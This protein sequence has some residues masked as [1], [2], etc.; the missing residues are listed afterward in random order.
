MA[1]IGLAF[2][3]F[4]IDL[5]V[6]GF[7]LS[8]AG[9]VSFV[10]GSLLLFSPFTPK[11]PAMPRLSVSPWLLGGMTALLV[12]FFSLALTAAL[13]AQRR[14]VL[15]SPRIAAGATGIALTALDPQ[16]VVQVQSE[17]WTART[18]GEPVAMGA[19]VEIVKCDGLRLQ[20]RP[21]NQEKESPTD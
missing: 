6:A 3:F 14:T 18:V 15:M 1:L 4:L 11:V 17:T 10:L 8:V 20:V 21:L 5:K 2:L 19:R 16:G 9:T 13:R 7:A 12:A